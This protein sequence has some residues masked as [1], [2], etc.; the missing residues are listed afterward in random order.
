MREVKLTLFP[1]EEVPSDFNKPIL[2][3]T[4]N[5]KMGTLKDTASFL[6]G[7]ETKKFSGF[8]RLRDKYNIK[9]WCYQSDLT[10][11]IKEE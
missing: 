4:A 9:W 1:T 5:G 11:Q 6:G 7:D 8:E 10:E 2:Y 3:I